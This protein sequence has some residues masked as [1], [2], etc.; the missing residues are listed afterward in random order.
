MSDG[1]TLVYRDDTA[2]HEYET[3]AGVGDSSLTDL[4]DV[5]G[6]PG[7][8]KAPV[9]DGTST[10]ELTHVASQ[11]YVDQAIS[12]AQGRWAAL[13]QKLSFV[14]TIAQP[15]E[16]SN[17]SV[18]MTPDGLIFGPY[19][20]GASAG[21]SIRY[22]GLDGQPFSAVT[23]L[24]YNM[25]YLDDEMVLLHIGA[26]PY[27]RVF[28]QDTLG[29]THDAVFSPGS[30]NYPGEGP[31][32]FQE[33][34]ATAGMWRY[35]DDAGTGGVPLADLQAA[36]PDDLITKITITLGFTD[37]TNLAGLLRWMQ[38]NGNRYTFGS[39]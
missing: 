8:G 20:D 11:E 1:T 31:G 37:G 3:V 30:Q 4:T 14:D 23:N 32:P 39:A 18:V 7:A 33:F 5:T 38:I 27:A 29:N 24:A 12:D 2:K 26:S 34:V 15:W 36:H 21:G 10:F 16:A 17:P 25:R 28:T 35:D 22:H 19:A 9:D 6:T 13:G